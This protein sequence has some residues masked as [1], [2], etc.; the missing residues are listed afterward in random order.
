MD[1]L[2]FSSFPGVLLGLLIGVRYKIRSHHAGTR[3]FSD[4]SYI[5]VPLLFFIIVLLE[6]KA[7]YVSV[8]SQGKYMK[9]RNQIGETPLCR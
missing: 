4:E 2:K 5:C 9:P 6:K 3:L 7:V 1:E 8:C